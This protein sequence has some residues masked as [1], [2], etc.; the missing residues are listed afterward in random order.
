MVE[1]SEERLSESQVQQVLGIV[2][3][4]FPHIVKEEPENDNEEAPEQS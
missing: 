1:E 2:A 4:H 3:Q